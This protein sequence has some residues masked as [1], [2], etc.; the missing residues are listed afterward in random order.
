GIDRAGGQRL[1]HREEPI[2]ASAS[3][4]LEAL[5]R[6]LEDTGRLHRESAGLIK[7]GWISAMDGDDGCGAAT[8]LRIPHGGLESEND[9]LIRLQPLETGRLDMNAG[10]VI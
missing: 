6:G 3:R 10:G 9:G 7:R 2:R 8:E 5:G 4:G 1:A